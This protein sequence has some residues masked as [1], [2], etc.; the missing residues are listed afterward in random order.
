[1]NGQVT[2]RLKKIAKTVQV[3][4]PCRVFLLEFSFNRVL[5]SDQFLVNFTGTDERTFSLLKRTVLTDIKF[6]EI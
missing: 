5:K 1:M 3:Q 6:N 4:C 2:S